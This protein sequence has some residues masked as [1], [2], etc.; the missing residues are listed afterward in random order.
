MLVFDLSVTNKS[1]CLVHMNRKRSESIWVAANTHISQCSE[2]L[3]V[4][5]TVRG[6][7]RWLWWV[8]FQ[9]QLLLSSLS[10]VSTSIVTDRS[11]FSTNNENNVQLLCD[12]LNWKD[13]Q[14]VMGIS[15]KY[16]FDVHIA[17]WGSGSP[18]CITVG[19]KARKYIPVWTP[20]DH[21]YS[22]IQCNNFAMNTVF[23]TCVVDFLIAVLFHSFI[24]NV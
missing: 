4:S 19:M 17:H 8:S 9:P 10:L 21:L 7:V 2:L 14:N 16:P 24:Q 20:T 6:N 12:W 11:I 18:S 15:S 23:E 5:F 22:I 1:A 13:A 3:Y